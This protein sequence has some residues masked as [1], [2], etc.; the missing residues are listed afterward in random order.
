MP[1]REKDGWISMVNGMKSSI[2]CKCTALLLTVC[3][4]LS[5]GVYAASAEESSASVSS[6]SESVTSSDS[7]VSS[8]TASSSSDTEQTYDTGGDD[9]EISL[10]S[11]AVDLEY[12]NVSAS[13]GSVASYGLTD[14]NKVELNANNATQ[15]DGTAAAAIANYSDYDGY[16]VYSDEAAGD[17]TWTFNVSKTGL[18]E[19]DIDYL[20]DDTDTADIQRGIMID[21]AYPFKESENIDFARKWEETSTPK[22][23]INGDELS[24]KMGQVNIWSTCGVCDVDGMFDSN[25]KYLLTEGTH[26]ITISYVNSN[27][28]VGNIN[29]TPAS[30]YKTY[31]E[32]E[33]GYEQ[34]GYQEYTGDEPIYVEAEDADY[35]SNQVLRRQSNSDPATTPYSR[36]HVVLNTIGG[37]IWRSGNQSVEYNITVPESG[38]YK[39]NIRVYQNHGEGLSVHRQIEIDGEV[40]FEEVAA[41]AFSYDSQWQ[42]D[43][44]SDS[45]GDPYLFYLSAGEHTVTFSVKMGQASE[46]INELYSINDDVTELIRNITKITGSDPDLNFDYEIEKKYPEIIETMESIRDRYYAQIDYLQ[47]YCKKTPTLANSLKTA[48]DQLDYLSK[49]PDKIPAKLDQMTD[50]Q[51]SVSQWYFDIQDQPM[52]MD[53]IQFVAPDENISLKKA[54][55]I[56]KA[57]GTFVNFVASFYKDY[58]SILYAVDDETTVESDT[59]LDVWVA[60]S[61]EMSE[62]LQT[63]ANEDFSLDTGIGVKINIL[64]SGSVG[65]V[66]SISPL[67]LA[68]ISGNVPDI[69]LGSDSSTPVELAIRGA[70]YDL[71]QFDD[72]DEVSSWFL[73]GAMTPLEYEGGYYALPENMDFKVMFYRKDILSELGVEIPQTWSDLYNKVLPI[74]NQNAMDFYMPSDYATFLFQNGGSFYNDDRSATELDS[75][76]AYQAFLQWTKN[77]TVYD[78]PESAE[79]YNHFRIGDIPLVI[80]GYAD[81]IKIL[82]AA[83]DL[84]GKWDI[85][86]IP[87]TYDENGNLNR[88][89]GGTSSTLMIFTDSKQKEAAWDFAKWWMSKDVQM[90]YSTEIEALMGLEAR[91]NTANVDAFYSMSWDENHLKVFKI[92]FNNYANMPSAL[93]GYYTARNIN[94]AWTRV[95]ESG[96]NARTSWE[97]CVDEIKNEMKRK[98]IEYGYESED[99]S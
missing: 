40:P 19:L 70:V 98:R 32:V 57:A 89:S 93:G 69:A 20:T 77:Y 23:D 38:L 79:I 95:V 58:D 18:Y 75:N 37:Y 17:L 4:V 13:Y 60:R 33:Q 54:S 56:E 47:S 68:V 12:E 99:N 29:V 96:V 15:E 44:V 16:A 92:V 81:Y 25:L 90:T 1:G 8:D 2:V 72:F 82:Y 28:Y 78:M 24:P 53:Y 71:S 80:G 6:L 10:Y 64:P 94:N 11:T 83:P 35:R 26:T 21:G 51:G 59:V 34:N 5:L 85:A 41:Y 55:F 22:L 50:V 9:Y 97:K 3:I 52:M 30:E 42:S 46:V 76:T 87:G 61:K 63:M 74:L 86:P 91:W 66:G 31:A 27:M 84:Y 14:A 73:P 45:N 43:T 36:G 7:T 88:T 65:A 67:M 48:A 39:L 49:N 62:V